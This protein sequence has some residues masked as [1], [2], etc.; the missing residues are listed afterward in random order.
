MSGS[1]LS[2][3]HDP[4]PA[5]CQLGR[6]ASFQERGSNKTQYNQ[7]NRSNTLPSDGGRKAFA[8]R[9]MKQEIT[10]IM[11]SNQVELHKVELN[12]V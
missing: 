12:C 6:Q 7:A 9:K 3:N 5:R 1:T 2:L 8:M 11:S 4:T 10:D